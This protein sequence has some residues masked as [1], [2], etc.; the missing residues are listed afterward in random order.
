MGGCHRPSPGPAR[1][2]RLSLASG[3]AKPWHLSTPD[4]TATGHAPDNHAPG[5]FTIPIAANST[6]TRLRA[7]RT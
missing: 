3:T 1:T 2:L 7:N 5:R 4:G 6:S